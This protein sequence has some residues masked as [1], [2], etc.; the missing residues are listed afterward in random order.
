MSIPEIEIAS[1]NVKVK[2][3]LINYSSY[4]FKVIADPSLIFPN[5]LWARIWPSSLLLSSLIEGLKSSCRLGFDLGT[6][7]GMNAILLAKC[8]QSVVGVDMI[9]DGLD[10]GQASA[11]LNKIQNV[12]FRKFNWNWTESLKLDA[13]LLVAA[14]CLYLSNSLKPI[15]SVTRDLLLNAHDNMDSERAG[16][17]RKSPGIGLFVSPC[18]GFEQEFSELLKSASFNVDLYKGSFKDLPA[19]I[20]IICYLEPNEL[21]TELR[22]SLNSLEFNLFESV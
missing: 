1:E 14:D 9:Q 12:E 22:Q 20:V 15:A 11:E 10:I 16:S 3:F 21:L 18:R 8:C 7:M 19:A 6:G 17:V 5:N 4:D 2:K 13:D